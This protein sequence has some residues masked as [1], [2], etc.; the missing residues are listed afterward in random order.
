M[1]VPNSLNTWDDD[2]GFPVAN[3]S[4]LNSQGILQSPLTG[5]QNGIN[6]SRHNSID[7]LS[8]PD[9][10]YNQ[11]ATLD[12]TNPYPSSIPPSTG[13]DINPL[14]QNSFFDTNSLNGDVIANLPLPP[15]SIESTKR[16]SS[17]IS[18]SVKNEIEEDPE[19]L[20]KRRRLEKNR[21]TAKTCRQRKKER[22]EAIQEE[23]KLALILL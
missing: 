4:Y 2:H 7:F 19:V 6:C 22:K 21:Q 15:V 18:S 17:S 11:S 20:K 16:P 23:V 3:S 13:G 8:L 10:I 5:P 14:I 12:S 1:N 9:P